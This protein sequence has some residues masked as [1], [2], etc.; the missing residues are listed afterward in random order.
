MP[1]SQTESLPCLLGSARLAITVRIYELYVQR[2]CCRSALLA[3][4]PP[5]FV[6]TPQMSLKCSAW[7]FKMLHYSI[8]HSKLRIDSIR[9]SKTQ[10]NDVAH[11]VRVNNRTLFI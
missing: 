8:V 10:R 7:E 5:R 6:P 2:C 3:K 9:L 4:N 1:A 11:T